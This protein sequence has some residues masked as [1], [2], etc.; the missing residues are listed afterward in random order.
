MVSQRT[1]FGK[2]LRR[3]RKAAQYN[4]DEAG[5]RGN[6]SGKFW[7]EVERGERSPTLDKVF[8]MA[9]ALNVPVHVLVKIEREEDDEK[10]LRKKIEAVVT[11]S[12]A[13]HLNRLYC[14]ILDTL[15]K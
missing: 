12:S 5:E 6:M 2:R 11:K 4:L 3:L 14:Y 8:G 7:G 13:R 10:I 9:K 1:V 15:E